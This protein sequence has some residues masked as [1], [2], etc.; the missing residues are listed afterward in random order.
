MEKYIKMATEMGAKNVQRFSISDIVFDPRVI[1]KCIFGCKDYGLLHTCPYQK[2]P[3]TM[4]EYQKIFVRYS[5]GIIIGC[6]DKPTS[7]EI[8][9]EIERECFLDGYYF[10]FS[11]SDC[12]LCSK[13]ARGKNVDC[14]HPDKARPAL[15]SVGVDVFKT[16][17]NLGLPI[18]VL[19]DKSETP[20]WYSA[21]FIE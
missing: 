8:S 16:V 13:C 5:W 11:L 21:V 3:L 12:G 7:Q 6:E 10:A 9:Y 18:G 20:N 19:R 2:S 17:R 14:I 1:L 15:H 4:D